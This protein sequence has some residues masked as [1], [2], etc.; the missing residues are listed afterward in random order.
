MPHDPQAGVI[1]EHLSRAVRTDAHR[2]FR[3]D[4]QAADNAGYLGIDQ[5][6]SVDGP[7]QALPEQLVA[8]PGWKAAGSSSSQGP[9]SPLA[10][11]PEVRRSSIVN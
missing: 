1:G 7:R 5:R 4:R 3:R 11:A 9:A 6:R 2:R 8:G 10:I